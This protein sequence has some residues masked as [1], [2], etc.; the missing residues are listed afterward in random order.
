MYIYIYIVY[1]ILYT[2]IVEGRQGE[3][4][5]PPPPTPVRGPF[6]TCI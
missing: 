5:P 1:D 6:K 2:H 4:T 3:P